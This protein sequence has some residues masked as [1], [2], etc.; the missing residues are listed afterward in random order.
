[1][2]MQNLL[3][4]ISAKFCATGLAALLLTGTLSLAQ[5][6]IDGH[7][8]DAWRVTGVSSNDT[9]NARMGPGTNFPVIVSFA[10]NERSL[11]QITCVPFHNLGQYQALTAAQLKALPPRWCLMRDATM[12]KAGWVAQR[13]ITPDNTVEVLAAKPVKQP[14]DTGD[15]IIIKAEQ[16]VAAL[17]KAYDRAQSSGKRDPLQPPLASNFSPRISLII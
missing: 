4:T 1:M 16:L 6:E 11:E 17:Y 7:G 12:A 15:A 2:P 9:L 5:A 8:P 3:Q 10:H 13:F 14:A